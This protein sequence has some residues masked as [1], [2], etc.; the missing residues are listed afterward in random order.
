MNE[1]LTPEL[2]AKIVEQF[3]K[4]DELVEEQNEYIDELQREL[5]LARTVCY[6]AKGFLAHRD[7]PLGGVYWDLLKKRIQAWEEW[8]EA[9]H[10]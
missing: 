5:S 4:S 9:Q 10:E 8:K 1:I 3:E 6:T 2:K 7:D